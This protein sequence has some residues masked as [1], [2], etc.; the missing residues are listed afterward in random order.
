MTVRDIADS[1]QQM[2]YKN[3]AYTI[4]IVVEIHV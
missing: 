4:D 3:T 1:C 2:L